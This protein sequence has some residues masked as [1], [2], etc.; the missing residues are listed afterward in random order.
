MSNLIGQVIV[1][2][3]SIRPAESVRVEVLG[4]PDAPTNKVLAQVFINGAPGA[5]QYLQFPTIGE[6]HLRI[7]AIAADGTMEETTE[8]LQVVGQPIEFTSFRGQTDIAMI[9]VTQAQDQPYEAVLTLG[10]FVD[11]RRPRKMN[12]PGYAG[13]SSSSISIYKPN[14]AAQATAVSNKAYAK[15][16][17][18]DG[19]VMNQARGVVGM[20]TRTFERMRA[21][22]GGKE[23]KGAMEQPRRRGLVQE[24][25]LDMGQVDL[26]SVFQNREL[27]N[28]PQYEWDF[29][30]GTKETTRTPTARHNYFAAID[31]AGGTG[32]FVVSCTAVHSGVQVQ[33]TLTIQS[34][35]A[36]CKR[37]G[38][39]APH[40]TSDVFAHKKFNRLVASF[41]V[42][43][44]ED[45]PLKLDKL[46]V[47]AN[48]D[49]PN[50]LALPRPFVTMAQPVV[51]A[52]HSKTM[53]TINVPLV[54][55]NPASGELHYQV[56]GFTAIYG[57]QVG[58][59]PARF[60]VVFD[61]PV[62]ERNKKP[63]PVIRPNE[64][65]QYKEPWPWETVVSTI[66]ELVNPAFSVVK[67][68]Q[69]TLD[70]KTSTLAVSL[71]SM[72]AAP[73]ALEMQAVTLGQSVISAGSK[74][75]IESRQ[76]AGRASI[77]K[78][79]PA[80][81]RAW[82]AFAPKP[83]VGGGY[84]RQT[85]VAF[86]SGFAS[87]THSLLSGPT[88]AGPVGEHEVCEPDNLTEDQL[89]DADGQQLVCQLTTEEV[90]VTMPARWGNARKGDIILAPGGSGLIGG[91]MLN[92]YPPQWYSHSGIMTRNFDEITHSTGS[93]DRLMDHLIGSASPG[94]D[95]FE[96]SVLK[97]IWPGAIRQTVGASVS[98]EIFN[99]PEY[100][101]TYSV[102]AFGPYTVGVTHNDQMRM[103]PPLVVK[104]DPMLETPAIRAALHAIASEAAANAGTPTTKTK[105]H[106]RWYCYTDPKIGQ[107]AA[108]GAGA[109][110]A[111]DTRPSVCSSYIWMMAKGK[112]AVLESNQAFVQPQDLEA[113]DIKEG[114]GGG[115]AVRPQTPDGLYLYTAAERLNAANWL[116]NEIYNQ[117]HNKA[118][119]FGT[120]V[121]DG[122]DDIASQFLNVFENDDADGKDSD[123]WEEVEDADAISPDNMLWWDGPEKGG[124]YGYAE[125]AKYIQP[126]DDTYKVSRWTKVLTRGHIRGRVLNVGQ[127]VPGALVQVYE[128]KSDFS[129][130][131]GNYE[132][133]DVPFG[134]YQIT[135]QKVIDNVLKSASLDV[136][137]DEENETFDISLL[138]PPERFRK[139]QV[140]LDFWGRD[141]K[142]GDDEFTDPGA[143]YFEV[144][145]SPDTLSQSTSREY[146]WGGELRAKFTITFRLLV[147]NT[148]DVQI[149][150]LLYEGTSEDTDDL[151][152]LGT[153]TFQIPVYQTQA[154]TLSITNTEEDDPDEGRLALSVRNERA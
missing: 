35:Y 30:D 110:W 52:P 87:G 132:I 130:S 9:G 149:D 84:V 85:G 24:T 34:A 83:L 39:V 111:A 45:E 37:T 109:G 41:V 71:G 68:D 57:G 56:S 76:A 55:A 131:A 98:G 102:K 2:Q 60:S 50:A 122:P 16:K 4:P 86:G 49:N 112:N 88:P 26:S 15:A 139:A 123:A 82:S 151:D 7:V 129:D 136:V 11:A 97:Y 66:D 113:S 115:A 150:G 124:L 31:H 65:K 94:S 95:G 59:Y 51:V 64:P 135:A 144:F 22:K 133:R 36:M 127:P 114:D 74:V 121:T 78:D 44:V 134:R 12:S 8:V 79:Q 73:S 1:S 104:P 101:K 5:L 93:Q 106:Y 89:T 96:P 99:D 140:L 126:Y 46:S 154:A 20:Q 107:G 28:T 146:K 40:V 70:Q 119:W 118:G 143:E 63:A 77:G 141:D 72:G 148:I 67:K 13:P 54:P 137:V 116:Y 142:S 53:V 14:K 10:S 38:K 42:Y 18:L 147:N 128:S 3:A 33:R 58:A 69:V 90:R 19:Y 117:A 108:E 32:Q 152:G 48:E 25:V 81:T 29:G 6:R 43:N 92:V 125:P 138:D 153:T 27:K 23:D 145:L 17:P 91:L 61:V 80:T 120:L 103:I 100:N 62:A 47:T 21:R 75:D 105:Y